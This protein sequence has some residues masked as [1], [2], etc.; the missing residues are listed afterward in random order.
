MKLTLAS[1]QAIFLHDQK[2]QNKN[3]YLQNEKSFFA[4]FSYQKCGKVKQ[5]L[6]V[7]TYKLRVQIYELRVQPHEIRVQIRK[8]RV[9]IYE[10]RVSIYE[11]LVQKH[12]LGN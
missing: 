4:S 10:L 11:L 6:R 1:Y 2:T 8:L 5:E 9:E 3:R 12:E 7:Q